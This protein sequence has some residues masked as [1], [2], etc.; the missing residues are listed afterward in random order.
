LLFVILIAHLVAT[1]A[2]ALASSGPVASDPPRYRDGLPPIGVRVV[3]D[4]R[5]ASGRWSQTLRLTI[6]SG[7][8]LADASLLVYGDL[9]HV[10]VIFAAA[11]KANPHL[12]SPAVMPVGQQ[13]DLPIDPS[14]TFALSGLTQLPESVIQSYTNGVVDTLYLKPQGSVVRVITFPSGKPTDAFTY[15]SGEGPVK[16]RPGGKLVDVVHPLGASYGDTVRQIFGVTTYLATTDLAMQTGWSPNSWP[17]PIG[18][19]H[20]VVVG[21]VA[22]Y[23]VMTA[24]ATPIPS[25]DPLANEMAQRIQSERR[26]VGVTL[27]R[28]ETFDQVYHIATND[29]TLKASDVSRLLY[30]DDAHAGNV[31]SAAGLDGTKSGTAFDPNLFGRSFDLTVEYVDE[32]FVA[33]GK[34][35]ADSTVERQLADGASTVTYPPASSG[36]LEVVH[37]PT[38]YKRVLYRPR[39]LLLGIANGLAL[40]H[41][42]DDLA[43]P[44][45]ATEPLNRRYVAEIIWRWGTSIPRASGDLPETIDL[46][47]DPRGAYIDVLIAP[48]L[49]ATALQ[50]GMDALDWGNPIVAIGALVVGASAL[51]VVVEAIRRLVRQPRLRW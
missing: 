44:S 7:G 26:N 40:F 4:G 12:P 42:A 31:T 5:D 15:S 22:T 50:R 32:R 34:V 37:Y 2:P 27:S 11:R 9:D 24:E 41:A 48:P 33:S 25:P 38:G 35:A 10:D 20:Q 19:S 6:K 14:T 21:P 17:P 16:V 45:S 30:N 46:V 51:V 13:I 43:L 8:S 1:T 49:P 18:E 29:T 36:P 23:T 28:V 3:A 39:P 47:D